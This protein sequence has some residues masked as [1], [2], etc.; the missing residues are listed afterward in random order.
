MW[1]KKR[2]LEGLPESLPDDYKIDIREAISYL[3]GEVK[4]T[5]FISVTVRNDKINITYANTPPYQLYQLHYLKIY[6]NGNVFIFDQHSY[7]EYGRFHNKTYIYKE[8]DHLQ[9]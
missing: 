3:K 5:K 7:H 2:Y 4:T 9:M 8:V 1:R 6:P